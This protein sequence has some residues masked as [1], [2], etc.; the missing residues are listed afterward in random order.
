MG[1]KEIHEAFLGMMKSMGVE[2]VE[3]AE[4]PAPVE[5]SAETI[6]NTAAAVAAAKSI[7][8]AKGK[9]LST[10]AYLRSKAIKCLAPKAG[11][12]EADK[13][14]LL[15]KAHDYIAQAME[16]QKKKMEEDK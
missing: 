12:S 5:A 11:L 16:A 10:V 8:S 15:Q 6:A 3:W 1:D 9:K 2:S 4:D 7:A 14:M 13:L